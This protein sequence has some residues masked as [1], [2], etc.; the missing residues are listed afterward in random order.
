MPEKR[1][2]PSWVLASCV[3]MGTVVM[4][5]CFVYI[6]H[7]SSSSRAHD[8]GG[9]S[10]SVPRS[11]VSSRTFLCTGT[12][13]PDISQDAVRS[14]L[15]LQMATAAVASGF[16]LCVVDEGSD[17]AFVAALKRTG[18]FV[19]EEENHSSTMGE[20]RRRAVRCAYDMALRKLKDVDENGRSL[21]TTTTA[22]NVVYRAHSSAELPFSFSPT[23]ANEP[24]ALVFLEPEK[25]PLI[26]HLFALVA[27][28]LSGHADLALPFRD[29]ISVESYPREQALTEELANRGLAQMGYFKPGEFDMVFGPF[30]ISVEGLRFV[31]EY[32][33]HFGDLW[34]GIIVPRLRMLL[35]PSHRS[36]V[37]SVPVPYIHPVEMSDSEEGKTDFLFKRLFQLNSVLN[38]SRSEFER[39]S[40]ARG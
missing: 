33:G 10:T 36:R 3:W 11:T 29:A 14:R 30:A 18:A 2:S 34:D 7:N 15:A 6:L 35:S 21:T 32:D 31:L 24:I 37:V 22:N 19:V 26:P 20:N 5:V 17:P 28:V 13:Y 9:S 12:K 27:P 8:I 16:E 39:W 25:A 23:D 4:L 38:A 1:S 40:T